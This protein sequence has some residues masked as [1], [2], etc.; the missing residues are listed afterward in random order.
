M[1]SLY[2]KKNKEVYNAI[3]SHFSHTRLHLWDDMVPLRR[4]A[5]DGDRILDI[6]CGN[7]RLYQLF[8]GLSIAYAGADHSEALIDIAKKKYPSGIFIVS[9]MTKLPFP[10][11]SFDVIFCIAVFHHLPT[12]KTRMSAVREM[13]RVLKKNGRVVM[14]NWNLL[15]SQKSLVFSQKSKK[16]IHTIVPWKDSKGKVLG[17]RHYWALS[18]LYLDAM[19]RK[20][21]F[22]VEEQYYM[23]RGERSDEKN[24]ENLLSIVKN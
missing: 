12:E 24:G 19:F 17:E 16:P 4:Y 1:P 22:I 7:G 8:D 10:N 23:K 3:A 6:G 2:I 20:A 5:K 13:K 18:P 15:R 14:M 21:G 11:E 9:D